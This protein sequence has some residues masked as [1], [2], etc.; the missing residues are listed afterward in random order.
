MW[1]HL[2]QDVTP[3]QFIDKVENYI[4]RN[5]DADYIFEYAN[6]GYYFS[7]SCQE[8][9]AFVETFCLGQVDKQPV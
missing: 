8:L 7:S 4:I 5:C 1:I 9:E 6:P 2:P 3:G